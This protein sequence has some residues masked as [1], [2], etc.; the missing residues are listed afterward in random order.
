[1]DYEINLK[2]SELCAIGDLESIK[3][4]NEQFSPNVNS[5]NKVNKW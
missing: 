2:F 5:Q 4:F 1:M 3:S